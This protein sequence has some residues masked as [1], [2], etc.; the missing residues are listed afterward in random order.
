MDL[1]AMLLGSSLIQRRREGGLG[2]VA[3]RERRPAAAG[4]CGVLCLRKEVRS[5]VAK[6]ADF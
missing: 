6:L 5:R 2:R 4:P 3:Y 1:F